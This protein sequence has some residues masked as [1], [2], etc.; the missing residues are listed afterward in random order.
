VDLQLAL[1]R[2][3]AQLLEEDAAEL[4][5]VVLPGVD[6]QLLVGFPQFAGNRGRLH[7]LRPVAHDRGYQ[8]GVT[9]ARSGL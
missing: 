2:R 9:R 5:V 6:E 4:V 3:D 1:G 7:E 8:H